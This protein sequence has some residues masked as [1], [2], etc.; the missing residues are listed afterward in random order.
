MATDWT[1]PVVGTWND[2]SSPLHLTERPDWHSEAACRGV[3]VNGTGHNI[4]YS[5]N[6]DDRRHALALCAECPVA[7]HCHTHA[8]DRPEP[9]GV[10]AGTSERARRR[11][12]RNQRNAA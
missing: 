2:D 5:D 4:F 8:I 10:W 9:Y 7:R 6:P 3:G 12:R 11:A 1:P